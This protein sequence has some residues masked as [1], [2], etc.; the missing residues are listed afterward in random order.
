MVMGNNFDLSTPA[1]H[2]RDVHLTLGSGASKVHVLKGIDLDVPLG[3]SVGIVG[4]SGSGKSTMLHVMGTLDRPSTGEVEVAGYQVSELT[5]AE[6]STLRA[7][8]I[9]F[10]F[11]QFHLLNGYSA[12]DNVADGMLYTMCDGPNQLGAAWTTG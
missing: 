8:H 1:I 4:P 2:L 6:L 12:L 9:G 10:V 7:Q 5:D 3:Q 11:Q